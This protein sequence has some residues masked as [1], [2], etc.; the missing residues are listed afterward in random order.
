MIA[1]LYLTA[2]VTMLISAVFFGM[3]FGEFPLSV[4][5][6]ELLVSPLW[7][8]VLFR[9]INR[10]FFDVTK[11]RG[12]IWEIKPLIAWLYSINIATTYM[13]SWVVLP[14]FTDRSIVRIPVAYVGSYCLFFLLP[15]YAILWFYPVWQ[16]RLE[17]ERLTPGEIYSM[18]MQSD[19]ARQFARWF[20]DH[21]AY[22]IDNAMRNRVSTCLLLHRKHRPEIDGL[23]EDAVLEVPIDLESRQVLHNQIKQSRYIFRDSPDASSLLHL[24]ETPEWRHHRQT[25][26]LDDSILNRFNSLVDRYPTLADAPFQIAIRKKEF[27]VVYP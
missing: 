16:K 1:V 25:I 3:F 9:S 18:A 11:K 15:T 12:F 21:T 17:Q 27:E 8:V 6:V 5:G 4:W 23:M 7:F 20:P 14:L 2:V 24:D 22:I 10:S 26:R 19:A 13:L